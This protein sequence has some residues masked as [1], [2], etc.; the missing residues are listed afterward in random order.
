MK[1]PADGSANYTTRVPE[2][3]KKQCY[4]QTYLDRHK[5][6]P[7]QVGARPEPNHQPPPEALKEPS[8]AR[9]D[10]CVEV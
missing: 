5:D 8:G 10:D 9:A 2:R 4:Q 6:G 1:M 7:G 3:I